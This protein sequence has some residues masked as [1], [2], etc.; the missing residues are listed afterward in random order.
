MHTSQSPSGLIAAT[1]FALAVASGLTA[2]AQDT[3][4]R[5]VAM[6]YDDCTAIIAEAARDLDTPPVTLTD[7]ADLMLVRI[8]ADDGS[9]TISCRRSEPRMVLTQVVHRGD[10]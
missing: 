6:P 9:M 1:A 4:T 10:D 7:T 2:M 8:D 5:V 3:R